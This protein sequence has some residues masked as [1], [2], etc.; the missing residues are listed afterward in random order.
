M[1]LSRP[2]YV[3]IALFTALMILMISLSLPKI[4]MLRF[5]LTFPGYSIFDRLNF[6]V[7]TLFSFVLLPTVLSKIMV[8]TLS[9]LTGIYSSLV[10]YY[11][12]NRIVAH[13]EGGLGFFGILLGLVGVGCT[14]CSPVVLASLFGLSAAVS[15]LALLPFKG[16]EISVS[17]IL[18]LMVS[19]YFIA[20]KIRDPIICKSNY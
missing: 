3:F 4:A 2:R 11:F 7:S 14:A 8:I 20:G 18:V 1:V 17:G 16:V 9:L 6:F 12:T 10:A 19:L 13:R 5:T 15:M